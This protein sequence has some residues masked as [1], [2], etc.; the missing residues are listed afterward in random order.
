MGNSKMIDGWAWIRSRYE[1]LASYALLVANRFDL[2]IDGAGV[3]LGEEIDCLRVAKGHRYGAIRE[4]REPRL[5]PPQ[6]LDLTAHRRHPFVLDSRQHR[7]ADHDLPPRLAAALG[8]SRV[9]H[10]T[11][12]LRLQ[13]RE[14]L[15]NRVKPDPDSLGLGHLDL[16]FCCF[17]NRRAAFRKGDSPEARLRPAEIH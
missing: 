11:I 1:P 17:Q 9:S 12:L 15:V 2:H 6:Q 5:Q 16:R 8:L 13:A 14:P 10:K 3:V 4:T 7:A